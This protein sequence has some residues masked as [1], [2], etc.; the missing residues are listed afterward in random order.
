MLKGPRAQAACGRTGAGAVSTC[1]ED[2][3]LEVKLC[4]PMAPALPPEENGDFGMSPIYEQLSDKPQL[5][6][7]KRTCGAG[8]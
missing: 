2:N 3:L 7:V 6:L 1:V 4:L 8:R 5:A